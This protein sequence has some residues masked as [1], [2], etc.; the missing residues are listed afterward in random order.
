MYKDLTNKVAVVTGGSKGIGKAI[1]E[2]FGKEKMCVVVNY[3][4]DEEGHKKQ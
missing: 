4:S 2:R 3:H 1:C